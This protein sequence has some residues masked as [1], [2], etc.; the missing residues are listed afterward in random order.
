MFKLSAYRKVF[1]YEDGKP[2]RK[3]FDFSISDSLYRE[4][5]IYLHNA[6]KRKNTFRKTLEINHD[7]IKRQL[8]DII[9][10]SSSINLET[11]Y[12]S[13]QNEQT[14]EID[15]RSPSNKI[16]LAMV[17]KMSNSIDDIINEVKTLKLQSNSCSQ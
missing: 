16:T 8:K 6:E 9:G 11:E 10:N 1:F 14:S 12:V 13:A 15:S 5:L 4:A 3:H 7:R 2:M 17:E